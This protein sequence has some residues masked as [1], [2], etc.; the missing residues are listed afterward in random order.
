MNE[1]A[2]CSKLIFSKNK[3]SSEDAKKKKKKQWYYHKL[4]IK[5][6]DL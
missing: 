2:K 3:L 4:G 1:I 5:I 6:S